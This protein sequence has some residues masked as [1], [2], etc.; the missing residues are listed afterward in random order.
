MQEIETT[1]KTGR[2]GGKRESCPGPQV[3]NLSAFARTCERTWEK[4]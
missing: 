1:N 2:K 4:K 3:A